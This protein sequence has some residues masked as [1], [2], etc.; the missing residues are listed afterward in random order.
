MRTS[1]IGS[2]V[3]RFKAYTVF[4]FRADYGNINGIGFYKVL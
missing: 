1:I 3:K 4:H 2:S